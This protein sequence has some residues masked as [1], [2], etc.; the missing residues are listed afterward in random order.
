MCGFAL[1]PADIVRFEI[2]LNLQ[3]ASLHEPELSGSEPISYAKRKVG[4]KAS[5]GIRWSSLAL[6][7]QIKF[8][9]R[10]CGLGNLCGGVMRLGRFPLALFGTIFLSGWISTQAMPFAPNV[11]PI[12]T[13]AGR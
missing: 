4:G 13:H 8:P 10:Q 1:V 11:A 3:P 5:N 12:D 7:F 2:G 9:D 6:A